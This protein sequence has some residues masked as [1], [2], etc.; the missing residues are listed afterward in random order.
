MSVNEIVKKLYNS[1][2][3]FVKGM[4]SVVGIND[5][6]NK[7]EIDELKTHLTERLNRGEEV[8]DNSKLIDLL[9]ILS[10][11]QTVMHIIKDDAEEWLEMLEA[12]ESSINSKK[13]LSPE[14][15]KEVKQINKMTVSIKDFLRKD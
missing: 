4:E 15:K 8:T 2:K 6:Y 9:E 7:D 5:K 1:V 14:E 11:D 3:S 13:E 12:I 10:K